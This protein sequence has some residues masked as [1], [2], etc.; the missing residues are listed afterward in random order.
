MN[1]PPS[2]KA[3]FTGGCACGAIRYES[4]AEPLLMLK[5]HCRDCQR[6]TGGG[7]ASYILL[8]VNAVKLTSGELR[9]HSTESPHMGRHQRGFCADCGSPVTAGERADG[10]S[11]TTALHAGSLDDPSGFQSQ[12]DVWTCDAQP[13][14]IM[15]PATP[16]FEK[17]PF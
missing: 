11:E 8:P 7:H 16:K 4:S 13:S 6:V 9:H 5:C 15:D 17:Y 12:M 10:T 3:P 1:N 2:I 14:T